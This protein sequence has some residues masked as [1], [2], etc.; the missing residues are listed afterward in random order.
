MYVIQHQRRPTMTPFGPF[1]T[2]DGATQWLKHARALPPHLTLCTLY[3]PE[4][5][6]VE[7]RPPAEV[8]KVD[9]AVAVA[10]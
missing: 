10:Q 4:W 1:P 5:Q 6:V 7:L 3:E 2:R 9:A 8:A